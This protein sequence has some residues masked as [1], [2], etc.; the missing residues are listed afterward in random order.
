MSW[1]TEWAPILLRYLDDSNT[2]DYTTSRLNYFLAMGMYEV[3]PQ[4]SLRS[5]YTIDILG[6]SITPDPAL[7]NSLGSL[8]IL[9]A[10]TIILRS[11]I[12][13]LAVVAGYS[14]KDDKST[15]DGKEALNTLRE[16]LKNY[17]DNYQ[18]ALRSY[19]L[20]AGH[21]GRAIL[22]PYTT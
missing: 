14:V 20:G 18:K 4:I 2:T 13:K 9:K 1:D 7:D 22:S 19:Q 10:A 3:I 16:M 11:E 21:I 12:K 5:T 6:P 8:V 17:E 15:I